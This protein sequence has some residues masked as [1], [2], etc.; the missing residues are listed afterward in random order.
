MAVSG[1]RCNACDAEKRA[2]QDPGVLW[3]VK[4]KA[5]PSRASHEMSVRA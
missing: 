5:R 1:D 2:A 4:E 3:A